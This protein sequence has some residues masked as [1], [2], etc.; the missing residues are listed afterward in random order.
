M[1]IAESDKITQLILPSG[2]LGLDVMNL[3][4]LIDD[5]TDLTAA[6]PLKDKSPELSPG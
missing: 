3:E 5:A 6:I 1:L 2:P 4:S